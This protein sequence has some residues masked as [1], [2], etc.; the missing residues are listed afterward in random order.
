MDLPSGG[1]S[2]LSHGPTCVENASHAATQQAL[3]W[4]SRERSPSRGQQRGQQGEAVWQHHGGGGITVRAHQKP[5]TR[6]RPVHELDQLAAR[7]P[8]SCFE[9]FV[10]QMEFILTTQ[11]PLT[12]LL[13]F[14]WALW[15][16]LPTKTAQRGHVLMRPH[17]CQAS[18]TASGPQPWATIVYFSR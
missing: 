4:C 12:G 7:V 13:P 6:P 8:G 11:P 16:A 17:S 14:L 15:A 9:D 18:R 10:S 2:A 5:G 1:P 3:T